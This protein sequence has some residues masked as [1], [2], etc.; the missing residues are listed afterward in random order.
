[1]KIMTLI[2][3]GLTLSACDNEAANDSAGQEDEETVFDP[4][5]E[6]VDKAKAVEG[7]VMQQKQ[8]MDEAMQRM[9]EGTEDPDE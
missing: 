7:T 3:L 8:D 2:A 4:L 1:M 5:I 6:S 9:E